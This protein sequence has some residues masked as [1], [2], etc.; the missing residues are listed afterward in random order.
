[1]TDSADARR[2]KS[3]SNRPSLQAR[4]DELA[5]AHVKVVLTEKA[6]VG[7]ADEVR[8]AIP[9]AVEVVLDDPSPIRRPRESRRA[10]QP[11]EAFHR[12]LEE[13]GSKDEA[14]ESL[15]AELLSEVEV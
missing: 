11:V 5:G 8:A 15:F 7:L 9:G 4:A 6:R 1:M 13:R 3:W 10:L 12:F 2:R 14:V